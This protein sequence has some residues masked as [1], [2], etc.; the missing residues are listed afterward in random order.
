MIKIKRQNNVCKR[1][2]PFSL[3]PLYKVVDIPGFIMRQR[4]TSLLYFFDQ[5]YQVSGS[6][7]SEQASQPHASMSLWHKISNDS[8]T[9]FLRR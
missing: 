6:P 3:P 1:G 8:E 7:F 5:N 2:A 9:A 4:P